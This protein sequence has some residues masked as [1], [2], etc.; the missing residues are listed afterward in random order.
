MIKNATVTSSLIP[1]KLPAKSKKNQKEI[2][3]SD[4][5]V[6]FL[7]AYSKA[8]SVKSTKSL[9]EFFEIRN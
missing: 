4:A 5:T 7:L 8:L 9:G 3:P 2:S 6:D 1:I